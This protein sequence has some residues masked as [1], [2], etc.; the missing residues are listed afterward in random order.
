MDILEADCAASSL[1]R[2]GKVDSGYLKVFC[3]TLIATINL[4]YDAFGN[5]QYR[6]SFSDESV[7]LRSDQ[8]EAGKFQLDTALVGV[9]YINS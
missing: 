9:E 1:D 7:S 3:P 5:P 2:T 8:Y 4:Q 6:L